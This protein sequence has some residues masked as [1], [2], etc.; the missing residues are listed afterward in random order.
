MAKD[1]HDIATPD[2]Y[3]IRYIVLYNTSGNIISRVKIVYGGD[4]V[5]WWGHHGDLWQLE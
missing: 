5:K 4:G 3:S 1:K 2:T